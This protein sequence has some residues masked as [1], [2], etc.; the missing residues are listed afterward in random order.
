MGT[1]LSI[2][3]YKLFEIINLKKSGVV[4]WGWVAVQRGAGLW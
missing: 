4:G 2:Q 3:N 1:A